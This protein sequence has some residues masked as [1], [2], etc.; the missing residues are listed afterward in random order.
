MSTT[1]VGGKLKLK[2]GVDPTQLKGGVKKKK[3]K[4]DK[5][6]EEEEALAVVPADGGA[7]GATE[8]AAAG[9]GG[10]QQQQDAPGGSK[11]PPGAVKVTREG[12]VLD[13]SAVEDRRT[14]AE[15]RA[16]AHFLKYEE[17]RARKAAAKSHRER[18]KELNEKLA[19][20]TEH[21]DLFRISYTA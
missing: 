18:I 20:L 21:H 13:P 11:L 2:G 3:K 19:T 6:K 7:E 12:V 10:D 14:E 1:F 16:D 15:K 17:Q 8:A 4:K 9:E 5:R